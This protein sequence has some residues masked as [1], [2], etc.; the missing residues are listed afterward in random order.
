M[1]PPG[2]P[3]LELETVRAVYG[4]RV[5]LRGVDLTVG[6]GTLVALAGPNGS[7]KTTLLRVALGLLPAAVGEARLFGT[8]VDRLPIA[9]RARRVAWVPQSESPRDDVRLFDYVLYGRYPHH[10]ALDAETES[11]RTIAIRVI[12]EVG[13]ADRANDGILTLSGG[14][15]QR[16]TLARALAQEAPLLL[17][18]EP[19]THLDIAHQLDLLERVRSLTRERGIAVVAALHDL[20]LAARFADRIVVL[21]RGQ[22]V[23]E[24]P[25]AEVLSEELLLRVWGVASERR[26]DPRTGV[27][28]LI[29]HR[30]VHD[31]PG[32]G[33]IA[34]FGPIHVVGGGGA[35]APILRA[36]ADRG[37]RVTSGALNLL[38]TDAEAAE[39]LGIPAPLEAPFAPI[40]PEVRARHRELIQAARV[41]VLGPIAVGPS[42][43]AN[44]EDLRS[45]AGT[46]PVW[47]VRENPAGAW[48]FTG[49]AASKLVEELKGL[50]A[51]SVRD[52][53]QL[54]ASLQ[55]L[56]SPAPPGGH[57]SDRDARPT[58]GVEL[59]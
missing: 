59:G 24:G 1:N 47:L 39:A 22:R 33:E 26:L 29:P 3:P 52:V 2:P 56:A 18:D 45:E 9:E 8:P 42:N 20:N 40:G 21:S 25:P 15:R 43:L 14:E 27:P 54:L 16:A 53:P 35:G 36:L 23:A 5:A 44:L 6:R 49:G 7:G 12:T 37:F 46:R 51:R 10:G 4:E 19:T 32:R 58:G 30:L 28:Y 55:P 50:G 13:L 31:E 17:L 38:D 34:G 11:D 41:V 48:D 57:G